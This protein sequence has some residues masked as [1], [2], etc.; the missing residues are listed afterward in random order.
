MDETLKYTVRAVALGVVI[1]Q[2]VEVVQL[3]L[4]PWDFLNAHLTFALILAYLPL[5]RT[6]GRWRPVMIVLLLLSVAATGYIH[7]N[8]LALEMRQGFPTPADSVAG[9]IL[10]V[11]ILE[12]CR[13]TTGPAVPVLA[14]L[15]ILYALLGVYLPAPLYTDSFKLTSIIAG[16]TTNL[17]GVYG[18]LLEISAYYIFLFVVMGGILQITAANNFFIVVGTL[19][20]RL[21]GGP[22]MSSVVTSALVGTTLGSTD[23]NV[24]LTGSFTIP[25]MKKSGYAP[26]QAG[27]IE[28]AASNGGMIMPPVMGAAAFVMADF[29]G[30]PYFTIA[31]A[32]IL[33][34]ILYF[35]SVGLYVYLTALKMR[36][37][38]SVEP[39]ARDQLK[40]LLITAPG[41]LAPLV[42]IMAL[43]AHGYSPRYAAFWAVL[44]VVAGGLLTPGKRPSLRQWIDGI[45]N[46]A[47]TGASIAISI[48][49]VAMVVEIMTLTGLGFRLPG[50]VESWSQGNL[51]LA[52]VIT[53]LASL[54]L[55]MGVP[56][57]PAYLIVA[58]TAA[59]VL[60]RLGVPLLT[61]HLFVFYYAVMSMVTPPVAPAAVVG[62]RLANA[63]YLKT[64]LE[65]AK[66]AAAGFLVPFI[67]VA[68]PIFIFQ[69]E[70]AGSTWM[71]TSTV[72]G[73]LMIVC[74]QAGLVNC[75]LTMLRYSERLLFFAA[76]TCFFL[77]LLLKD[78][79]APFLAGIGIFFLLIYWQLTQRRIARSA[80]RRG[81][82]HAS[83]S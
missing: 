11:C 31:V 24:A 52:L 22:A 57:T 48:V 14:L 61:A 20:A 75:F 58:I 35:C 74:M 41:F 82:V 56:P 4:E 45:T 81:T 30:V 33:P 40:Q 5:I 27:A 50:M 6:A 66:A 68:S 2:M 62:A 67:F 47:L 60:V 72:A 15:F 3:L 38:P 39:F 28:S 64:S 29:I 18:L 55:G 19:S 83:I 78:T 17:T 12:A 70:I 59:P 16:L 26:H 49:T 63:G 79:Y 71:I 65:A 1:Y 36:L 34:A 8:R 43:L 51:G 54:I 13:R 76:G 73:L 44:T 23:A 80:E 21:R 25:L 69:P 77:Y 32:A 7:V 53:A 37:Q 10:I 46:G 9:A 42:V